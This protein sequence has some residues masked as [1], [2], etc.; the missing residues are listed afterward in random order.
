M[1]NKASSATTERSETLQQAMRYILESREF[2]LPVL[3]EVAAEL[4]KQTNDVNCEP[5]CIVNLIKRDQSLTAH[6]LKNANSARY[7]F[8]THTVSSVHQAVARLG[9]LKVREIV[10]VITCQCR[11]FDVPGFE[12]DV[13]HSFRR[14]LATA[15]FAQETARARRQNVEDAFLSGLL[16]DVGRPILLQALIDRR[17][18]HGLQA[19]D[20]QLRQAADENR[21][22]LA[23]RLVEL[24]E[25]PSHIAD[26]I[27]NQTTPMENM[28]PNME[29]AIL[30]LAIDLTET[31]LSAKSPAMA[32]HISHPMISVLGLDPEQLQ[33]ILDNHTEILDWV[34]S[35]T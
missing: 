34:N 24:W 5:T 8:G 35:T 19:D 6:L 3:P 21:I 33:E 30:N 20:D 10:V 14:S 26:A 17:Q 15:V 12:D 25:L 13:R 18:L 9:L 1:S 31:T 2:Q 22:P 28:T 29:S 11:I 23:A 4:L 7:N 16:H 27:S 32:Q